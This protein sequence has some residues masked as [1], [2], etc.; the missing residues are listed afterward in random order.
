MGASVSQEV[1]LLGTHAAMEIVAGTVLFTTGVVLFDPI[2]GKKT[3]PTDKLWKRWHA[4]GLLI[5]GY[6][7]LLGLG[8]VGDGQD[9][10]TKHA[11]DICGIFHGLASVAQLLAYKDGQDT[12]LKASLFQ[13]HM[14]M[15]IGFVTL[16]QKKN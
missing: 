10:T 1:L 5:M 14:W 8:I 12:F 3:S 13:V 6:V 11:V 7:G 15:T 9:N 16:S 2:E 4:C